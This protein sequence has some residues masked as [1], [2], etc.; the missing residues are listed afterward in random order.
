MGKKKEGVGCTTGQM[1]RG[2]EHGD[3]HRVPKEVTRFYDP[4][5]WSGLLGSL[6]PVCLPRP[7]I[8]SV[9]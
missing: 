4:P 3:Q 6:A 8:L 1:A 9:K 5:G 2:E 7:L